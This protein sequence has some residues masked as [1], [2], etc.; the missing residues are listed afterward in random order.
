MAEITRGHVHKTLLDLSG[1]ETVAD[2][3]AAI[4]KTAAGDAPSPVELPLKHI[5]VADAVFQW[6]LSNED[7]AAKEAHVHTLVRALQDKD[8]LDPLL[9]FPVGKQAY[10][11]D[12]HHRLAAYRAVKWSGPVPVRAFKGALDAARIA[13]LRSNVK[14]KLPMTRDEKMEAAWRLVKAGNLPVLKIKEAT[15][16]SRSHI[17]NMQTVLQKLA[18]KDEDATNLSWKRARWELREE[19]PEMTDE[20]YIQRD[21]RKMVDA[22]LRHSIGQGMSKDVRVTARA[23]EMLNGSLPWNLMY[24]WSTDNPDLIKDLVDELNSL[25][26]EEANDPF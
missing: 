6:R 20:D 18:E 8:P 23:L 14:D 25:K 26:E 19:K 16:I 13:A 7:V 3:E 10:V 24:E 9:V 17:Y 4:K 15:T 21:A 11:I 1:N 5:R 22:L 12:G 2:L